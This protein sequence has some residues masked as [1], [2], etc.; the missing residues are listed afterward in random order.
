MFRLEPQTDGT[1]AIASAA[2]SNVHL[3]LDGRGVTQPQGAGGGVVNC[4]FGV[5]PWEKFW[6]EPQTDGT[7]AI[8]SA[9]FSNVHLR[10]D[11]RGVTQPQ[12]AGGGVVNCQFGAGPWETFNL[13]PVA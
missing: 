1:V 4:Q 3:R 8:A 11:G 12:G 10:L 6:L 7:V 2:F 9:A 5:G 13:E